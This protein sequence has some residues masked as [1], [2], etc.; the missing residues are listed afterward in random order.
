M[1]L[2]TFTAR[3][4][5]LNSRRALEGG[6]LVLGA[7]GRVVEV[8]ERY[9]SVH[10]NAVGELVDLGEGVLAPGWVNAHAHLELTSLVGKVDSGAAFPD[11]IKALLRERA[12]LERADYDAA[13]M[14]GANRLLRGGTTTVGDVDSSGASA[15]TLRG[16]PIR[17][18][19]FKEAL[20]VGDSARCDAVIAALEAPV[21]RAEGLMEGL[22]PHAGYTVSDPLLAGLAALAVAR[23]LPVQVHWNESLDELHWE[24]GEQSAFDGV[25]PPCSGKKTL[26]RLEEAGLLGQKTSLVH[27]NYSTEED[28]GLIASRGA[29]VVHCPGAHAFFERSHFGLEGFHRAGV[30]VALGTDS[31]AGNN[32]LEMGEE[33]ALLRASHPELSP[34][35]AFEMATQAS[36]VA[37]GL[38]G[39]VGS[40]EE[41]AF[42][43]MV[44]YEGGVEDLER[45]TSRGAAVQRVWVGGVEWSL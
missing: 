25:V 30:P 10:R 33:V 15:R 13:V 32:A 29:V 44:L 23:E 43:D 2:R 21:E 42:G 28:L 9:A 14:E 41:G 16:H 7:D 36:A 38:A 35:L 27:A 11:W 12:G 5:I 45:I 40:L 20:D 19:V 34:G 26:Q 8:I 37:L 18:L 31:L 3:R 17:S 22:S 4:V 39:E 24:R 6:A 1:T